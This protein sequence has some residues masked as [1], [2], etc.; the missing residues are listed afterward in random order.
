MPFYLCN[1]LHVKDMACYI[2]IYT[3]VQKLCEDICNAIFKIYVLTGCDAISKV[4]MK[5]AAPKANYHL[6]A[7]FG[8]IRR[9]NFLLL[10]QAKK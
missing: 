2:P 9:P 8:Q 3:L 6:R 10:K 4:G 1:S 5:T 7:H